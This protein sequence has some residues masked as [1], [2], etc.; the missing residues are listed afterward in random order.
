MTSLV[1]V[2]IKINLENMKRKNFNQL[3]GFKAKNALK[4]QNLL[5]K[6]IKT[7]RLQTQKNF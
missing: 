1:D 3:S 5:H 7:V 2:F 6:L 4:S